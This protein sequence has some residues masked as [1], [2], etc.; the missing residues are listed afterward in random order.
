MG[1]SAVSV[2]ISRVVVVGAGPGGVA[3][4]ALARRL[5]RSDLQVRVLER[6]SRSAWAARRA[7]PVGLWAPACSVL[8]RLGV[9]TSELASRAVPGGCYVNTAG[10]VLAEPSPSA[11]SQG[12]GALR[13]FGCE[14]ELLDSIAGA[15]G[16]AV[17]FAWRCAGGGPA[18]ST[19]GRRLHFETPSGPEELEADLVVLASGAGGGGAL[20]AGSSGPAAD[21]LPPPLQRRGY[22]VYRG[23]SAA[24]LPPVFPTVA[25]QTWGPGMRFAA[26]PLMKGSAWYATFTEGH[27]LSREY[28]PGT[29]LDAPACV[30]KLRSAF[31]NW[32]EPIDE[33]LQGT[34]QVS[35]SEAFASPFPWRA[36]PRGC[37]KTVFL[38]D[39]AFTY[40][41][42]LAV[43]AGEAIC[44]AAD[45]VA[46]L[47]AR[48][49]QQP[50]PGGE[51]HDAQLDDLW[52]D[53][54]RRRQPRA[55]LL[56]ALS[57]VAEVLGQTQWCRTRDAAT[58]LAPSPIKRAIF[59]WS[60]RRLAEEAPP[61]SAI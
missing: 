8:Q 48:L 34:Q 61:I 14:A 9:E 26:V 59:D 18:S 37:G 19:G 11:L 60:I 58:A 35:L 22:V 7:F 40:D 30:E 55:R 2:P 16:V 42:I 21:A 12:A 47:V 24:P 23:L 46:A 20:A 25:F 51:A 38:G 10:R 13:F 5:G 6:D 17:D 57:N 32:H 52:A 33:L 39:A 41:P 45:V 50:G 28:E 53:L 29:E 3:A 44:D 15:Q 4:A 43:G 36:S 1:R 49:E 27:P 54:W 31:G 56:A